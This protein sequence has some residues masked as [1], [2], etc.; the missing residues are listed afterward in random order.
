VTQTPWLHTEIGGELERAEREFLH[1]NGAGAYCMSTLA[2]LHSRRQHGL[3]VA[4]LDPPLKRH[5]VVSH[6]DIVVTTIK[7]TYR[8]SSYRFPGIA[9]TPG[10]RS[11]R[12][13][14]QDPLPRFSYRLGKSDF[15]ITLALVRGQNALVMEFRWLGKNPVRVSMRP[16]LAMRPHDVLAREHG[17]MMQRVSLRQGGVEIQ[18]VAS[19]PP[20]IIKHPGV[21][22]GSPD[23]W[24]RFEYAEDRRSG[25][26]F[27]E[28]LWTP[29][30]IELDVVPQRPQ[31]V[32]LALERL[33]EA[34]AEQCIEA[35]RQHLLALDPGENHALSVRA[36]SIAADHFRADLAARPAIIAGYP[37]LAEATRDTL[38]ALPGLYLSSG[39]AQAAKQIVR[40]VIALAQ[41]GLLGQ[42]RR[43]D[44]AV[45]PE[46]T[47]DGSLWLFD[48]A[49]RLARHLGLEDAFVQ[50]QLYP[51]LQGIYARVVRTPDQLIWRRANGLIVNTSA[52]SAL[53]WMD[54]RSH[55]E[56][57]VP[58]RGIAI[59]LQALW[60]S[61]LRTLASM[62]AAYGDEP[63][64]QRLRD[65][66]IQL[67]AAFKRCF[68]CE[69]SNYPYDC[70][71]P[72]GDD[73]LADAAIRPNA[74]VALA[75]EPELF[76]SWQAIRILEVA[77]QKL[78]TPRGLR[79][80]D[81][82]H[83]AYVGH[84]DPGLDERHTSYHR[85]A[86]WPFLLGAYARAALRVRPDD[87]ELQ[88]D[89]RH[90]LE[91]CAEGGPVLG[92]IA[93]IAGGEPPHHA[94]GCPAQAWSTAEILRSLAE[95][96]EL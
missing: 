78:V 22:M 21:F 75:M 74:V 7:R 28:D 62:A 30:T 24:R 81:P 47:A 93:Q 70:L 52:L 14:S 12:A 43:E 29:G 27:E 35:S 9:P 33:P 56:I 72:S 64:A 40:N 19:L 65:E 82:N 38:V 86:A 16:L 59:E 8:L 4:A 17:A 94:G 46:V 84:Y 79:T 6:A 69:A 10:Y 1:T 91:V 71:D 11:L 53:T 68:W 95:D 61:A 15:E 83:A 50:Q 31:H 25:G 73:N 42:G 3:L 51:C 92:H 85:G 23:W 67:I 57:Q 32:T 76:Q 54:S 45:M 20:L 63:F 44:G 26:A 60:S 96:L 66:R 37:T 77:K 80:L 48:V 13:F 36:L 41:D 34:S 5:V 58:R 2:L 89:L 49:E 88:V 90:L 87:F 18:P 39:R 55:G